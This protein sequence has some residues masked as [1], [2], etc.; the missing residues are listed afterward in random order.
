MDA[1]STTGLFFCAALS[2]KGFG[3]AEKSE[4]KFAST[5]NADLN[6]TA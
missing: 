3:L 4:D 6:Q 5:F 2:P 1:V